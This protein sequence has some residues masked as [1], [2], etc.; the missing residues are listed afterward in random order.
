MFSNVGIIT[1]DRDNQIMTV[2]I[3]IIY[4]YESIMIPILIF[5]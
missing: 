1:P 5:S 4:I 2:G 3:M